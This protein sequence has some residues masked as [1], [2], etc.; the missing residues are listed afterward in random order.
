MLLYMHVTGVMFDLMYA[1]QRP[2]EMCIYNY[3]CLTVP[4][5]KKHQIP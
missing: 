2:K 1:D 3:I 5:A 4:K